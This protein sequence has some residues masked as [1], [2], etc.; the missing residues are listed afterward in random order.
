M[1]PLM[2]PALDRAAL[3]AAL[4]AS[5]AG[6]AAG[7]VSGFRA[8][9][10]HVL[11]GDGAG[12]A[13]TL[14][15]LAGGRLAWVWDGA[16]PLPPW[17]RLGVAPARVLV[18]RTWSAEEAVGAAEAA[19]GA[20]G[21]GGVVLAA[22]PEEAALRRLRLAAEAGGAMAL[23]LCP[24]APPPCWRVREVSAAR[25]ADP[26]WEV[27]HGRGAPRVLAWRAA[28]GALEEEGQGWREAG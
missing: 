22:A 24:D 25:L 11:A 19:L 9:A 3:A 10:L 7:S 18:V 28:Q 20:P 12:L 27:A 26:R 14:A 21:F 6:P 15:G 16:A 2:S 23:L 13:A 17:S 1:T 4:A 5:P 8:A